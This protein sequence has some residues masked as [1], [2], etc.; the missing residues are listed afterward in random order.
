MRALL[1]IEFNSVSNLFNIEFYSIS[2]FTTEDQRLNLYLFWK[3]I[4]KHFIYD[5]L[6]FYLLHSSS[7]LY[8]IA[9]LLNINTF[10]LNW[11]IEID[12][13]L[14][15]ICLNMSY[16]RSTTHVNC[17]FMKLNANIN[18]WK[19]REVIIIKKYS[20]QLHIFLKR[21]KI[22]QEFSERRLNLIIVW[23]YFEW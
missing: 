22:W 7:V 21:K 8:S 13:E 19:Y 5:Y 3:L 10:F 11:S 12:D 14:M 20:K 4:L 15:Q 2:N 16:T 18:N 17:I 9:I 6:S 23:L 1:N